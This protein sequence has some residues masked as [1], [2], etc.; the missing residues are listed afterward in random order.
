MSPLL[1]LLRRYSYPLLGALLLLF[2][3][4]IYAIQG[5][6]SKRHITYLNHL[7][8]L[9]HNDLSYNM[10]L[11]R[12]RFDINSDFD[13]LLDIERS[14]QL[15]LSLLNTPPSYM[16]PRYQRGIQNLVA[17]LQA[18]YQEKNDHISQFK[19]AKALYSNS[20]RYLP[21]LHVDIEALSKAFSHRLIDEVH[22]MAEEV[23]TYIANQRGE[24]EAYFLKKVDRYR[25]QIEHNFE[26][27]PAVEKML[28]ALLRHMELI[29]SNLPAMTTHMDNASSPSSARTIDYL[30]D[31][32]L[33]G[34]K[35]QQ[36]RIQSAT[37]LLGIFTLALFTALLFAVVNL[38]HTQSKLKQSNLQLESRVMERTA[39]L[40][41]AKAYAESITA[42]MSEALLVLGL[43]GKLNSCNFAAER[44]T[45]YSSTQLQT[46]SL[47]AYIE[48]PI[49]QENYT[50]GETQLRTASGKTHP[51]DIS[52][53]PLYDSEGSINGYTFVI[54]DLTERKHAEEQRQFLAFQSGLAEMGITVMHNIGNIITGITGDLQKSRKSNRIN[55]KTA[56]T[57]ELFC[58]QIE[59]ELEKPQ[60]SKESLIE[61]LEKSRFIFT[62][63]NELI[64][65]SHL[66]IE[67]RIEQASVK[68]Q[69]IGA[70]I[71]L[72]EQ[73][74]QSE[75]V[76]PSFDLDVLIEDV[77]ST[78]QSLFKQQ[79]I[80][81]TV[82]LPDNLPPIHLPRNQ[83]MQMLIH[84]L[85]NSIDAIIA[86]SDHSTMESTGK[87][88][89][90]VHL[91]DSNRWCLDFIDNGCGIPAGQEQNIFKLGFSTHNGKTGY[92]LHSV[93][94][95]IQSHKGT[96]EARSEGENLGSCFSACFPV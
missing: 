88:T 7:Q 83:L 50:G 32:Y 71:K 81:A 43:D 93:G 6:E 28:Q 79:H 22:Y 53:S 48:A 10:A 17:Q 41:G 52:R 31:T 19:T 56:E 24:R 67:Q 69:K 61:L 20:V 76:E 68:T 44:L 65:K 62:K 84:M 9:K 60:P 57:F 49:L 55:Q 36:I 45:G 91:L 16:E 46:N 25:K 58:R 21:Q 94:T 82:E 47:E 80:E 14:A 87:I 59:S 92:G 64:Q 35:K 18:L 95:F 12:A 85:Q 51:I 42:S 29:I 13:Q 63:S 70:L 39:E 89:I 74:A 54:H 23:L 3:G 96:I 33:A 75:R 1:E 78:K 11:F 73:D 2:F 34:Y 5:V 90:H 4:L 30:R 40:A 66:T 72:H 27:N 77:L 37:Q 26:E 86:R 15:Q 38:K 8:Q